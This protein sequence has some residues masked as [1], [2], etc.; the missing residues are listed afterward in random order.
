MANSCRVENISL[1]LASNKTTIDTVCPTMMTLRM[2][3]LDCRPAI[4]DV[5]L[6]GKPV[7]I[8]DGGGI[9]GIKLRLVP[10]RFDEK[11][12]VT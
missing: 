7:D 1:G 5:V 8:V 2:Y 9:G 10:Q 3:G 11:F 12:L 6:G 4:D